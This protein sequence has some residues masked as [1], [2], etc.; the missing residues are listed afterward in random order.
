MLSAPLFI[1]FLGGVLPALLWLTFWLLED[2][3]HPE[4]KWYIFFCF[5]AGMLMVAV[6]LP[7]ERLAL[8]H[9]SGTQLLFLWAL[10]EEVSKFAA[11]YVI[12]LH[13][14]VFDEPLD[15]IIY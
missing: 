11:A 4:P 6:V 10:T 14:R 7:I 5:V 9:T 2:R 8:L 1:A 15:A 12:A 3:L 13:S